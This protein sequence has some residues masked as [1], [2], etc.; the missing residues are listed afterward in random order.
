[1]TRICATA[2]GVILS[3]PSAAGILPASLQN[4]LQQRKGTRQDQLCDDPSSA[5][6]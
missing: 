5:A 6:F 4:L 3:R 1:M 2:R